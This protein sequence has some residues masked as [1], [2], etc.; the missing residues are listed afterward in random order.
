MFMS[1]LPTPVFEIFFRPRTCSRRGAL[2]P[3]PYGSL[4]QDVVIIVTLADFA[5]GGDVVIN[6]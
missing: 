6:Q 3:I 1:H 4:T 2:L 5:I